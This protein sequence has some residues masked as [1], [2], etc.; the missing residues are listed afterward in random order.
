MAGKN[1]AFK[2]KHKEL[3]QNVELITLENAASLTIF[4]LRQELTRRG[5]FDDTF[6]A[7]GEKRNINFEA[8]LEVLVAELVKEKDV[9]QREHAA[10][11]DAAKASTGETI[12]QKLARQKE[13][14]KQAALERSRQRQNDKAYFE[15]RKDVNK[16]AAKA[17]LEKD[18]SS[19]NGIQALAPEDDTQVDDEETKGLNANPFSSGVGAGKAWR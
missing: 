5:I 1:F 18:D 4:Q 7:D 19:S 12:E 16:D 10:E 13:E 3:G 11:L 2:T 6:G 8:C 14:R 15:V 9:A 17:K